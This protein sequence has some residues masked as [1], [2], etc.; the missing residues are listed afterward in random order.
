MIIESYWFRASFPLCLGL[1]EGHM[2][3]ELIL[4]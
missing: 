1:Q 2:G 4:K 3:N